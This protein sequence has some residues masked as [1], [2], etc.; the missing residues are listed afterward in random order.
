MIKEM[1]FLA[2]RK[3]SKSADTSVYLFEAFDDFIQEKEAKNLSPATLRNY[4][5]SFKAF[6]EYHELTSSFLLDEVKIGMVYQWINHMKQNEVRPQSINHYLRDLRTFFNWCNE[7]DIIQEPIKIKE[8]EEQDNLPKMYSDE[9]IAV[10]LEKPK[11]G[12]SFSDWRTWA[13]ISTV[14]STGMRASTLCSLRIDS[15][16]FERE[17]ITIEKQK[18]KQAG[19]LPMTNALASV[20]KE[21]LRKWLKDEAPDS[22]LFPNISGYPLTT[23]ALN[24]SVDRYCERREVECKGIHSVRHNFSRD[25]ILN[26]AGEFRLQRYLQHSSIQM[27]QKYVKLF[28]ADLKKDAESYN[29]LDNA[30]KKASRTSKFRKN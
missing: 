5:K 7:R 26:G 4:T 27:S 24:H 29:P 3:F 2:K 22:F 18:N 23:N 6:C 15:L 12:D 14:Y 21:Y 20:L 25:M 11:A 17:E 10:L 28:T 13:M 19:I 16:N 30:K 8:V 9:E 1:I